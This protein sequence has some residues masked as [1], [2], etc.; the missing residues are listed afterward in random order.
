MTADRITT[1][2]FS[3]LTY[4]SQKAL[5]L[6]DSRGILV[7][8]IRDRFTGYRYYTVSQI[9]TALKIKTLCSLGFGLSEI[10]EIM[11]ALSA[12]DNETVRGLIARRHRETMAEIGRLEKIQSLLM[13][14][15]DFLE[16]FAMNVS[17]PV[18]K[19]VP[20]MRIISGRRTGTY[21]EV[22]SKVSD[23]LFAIVLSPANRKNGVA[24]TGPCMSLCYDEEY[25]ESDADI[26]MAVPVRG[27]VVIDDPAYSVRTLP[28]AT[29]ISVVYKGPYVHE[30]FSVAFGN[31]FRFAAEHGFRTEGPDRQLYLNNPDETPEEELL[32]EIQVP[33]KPE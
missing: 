21:E 14:K 19:E 20:A 7:P 24:I 6:Y 17:E 28:G 4:L 18:I 30:G 25:R 12:G 8:E 31:A 33:V 13:E 11:S 16:L 26:E 22:C 2:K 15:R 3:T 5:R 29:V 23:D 1:G 9:E 27:Q 10:S 32:I